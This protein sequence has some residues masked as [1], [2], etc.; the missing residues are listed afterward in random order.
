[1]DKNKTKTRTT[2]QMSTY[3]SCHKFSMVKEKLNFVKSF[4]RRDIS[5]MQSESNFMEQ[6]PQKK[7]LWAIQIQYQGTHVQMILKSEN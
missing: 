3:K 5:G 2:E 4:T 6:I 7:F 1:M